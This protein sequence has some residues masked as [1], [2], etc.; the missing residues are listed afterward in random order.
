M[1]LLKS[2]LEFASDDPLEAATSFMM[3]AIGFGAIMW[4]IFGI[5]IIIISGG[6]NNG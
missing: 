1:K 5:A 3:F 4:T 2:L 6:V